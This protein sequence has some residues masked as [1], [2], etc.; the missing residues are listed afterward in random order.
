MIALPVSPERDSPR[1]RDKKSARFGAQNK[2]SIDCPFSTDRLFH[3]YSSEEKC[4]TNHPFFAFEEQRRFHCCESYVTEFFRKRKT[5]QTLE[6]IGIR[7]CS[8]Q[9]LAA[10][11]HQNRARKFDFSYLSVQFFRFLSVNLRTAFLLGSVPPKPHRRD[12]KRSGRTPSRRPTG[13]RLIYS[14]EPR[15]PIQGEPGRKT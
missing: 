3:G 15:Y 4:R 9:F 14:D 6:M 11:L 7:A 13:R 10:V 12:R 8:T 2:K 5:P 1:A